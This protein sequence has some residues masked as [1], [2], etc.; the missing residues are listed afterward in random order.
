MAAK[1]P[2]GLI[3]ATRVRRAAALVYYSTGTD[4]VVF[5]FLTRTELSCRHEALKLLTLLNDWNSLAQILRSYE[6]FE[7]S[8]VLSQLLLLS[9]CSAIVIEGTQAALQDEEYRRSWEWGAT[10][11]HYHFGIRDSAW[12][13]RGEARA[14]LE[15]RHAQRPSPKLY[16]EHLPDDALPL[17]PVDAGTAL[18]QSMDA[19]R[20]TRLF[21]DAPISAESLAECLYSG[22]GIVAFLDDPLLGR[23]PFKWVPSPGARNAFEAYV[24]VRFVCGLKRGLYQCRWGRAICLPSVR[25][26]RTRAT[27]TMRPRSYSWLHI[28]TGSCGN[29]RTQTGIERY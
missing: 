20:S 18:Y 7:P 16:R 9:E 8:S 21:V 22:F 13:S 2:Q 24:Y 29:T 1:A 6:N 14:F 11:G 4:L 17:P 26:L 15:A 19:R 23:V 27:W 25:C 12:S 28:S 10:A 3:E 5:N